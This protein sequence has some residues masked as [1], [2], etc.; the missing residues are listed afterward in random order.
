MAFDVFP[1][2][3][4]SQPLKKM[5]MCKMGLKSLHRR[6]GKREQELIVAYHSVLSSTAMVSLPHHLTKAITPGAS[7][8][9]KNTH[10]FQKLEFL[11]Q[12]N[13]SIF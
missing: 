6:Q 12:T 9:I 1:H 11:L 7:P 10:N 2:L 5:I 3:P 13:I 4:H 8:G